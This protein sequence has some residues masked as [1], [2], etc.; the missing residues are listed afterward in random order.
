LLFSYPAKKKERKRFA[1]DRIT[2]SK[3][4]L[5]ALNE[6]EDVGWRTIARL[7]ASVDRVTDIPQMSVDDVMRFGITARRAEAIV[8]LLKPEALEARLRV[9]ERAGIRWITVW[10][11]VY[12][13]L[14]RHTAEP[15]WVLYAIGDI[16]LLNRHCLAIVGTRTPTAYGRKV[17]ENLA[18][19]LVRA[20]FCIVS[21]MA[22]GIDSAAH[23]GALRGGGDTIAVLA[24]GVE[25]V[26]PPE[27]RPLYRELADRGLIVS[28]SPLGTPMHPG[29]F[30]VRN[31]IIAG[32][33]LGTIVVEAADRSG[34][35]ITA[36]LAL[37]ASRDVFAVPGPITSPKSRGTLKL[38]KQGA[39][40]VTSPDDIAEEYMHMINTSESSYTRPAANVETLTEEEQKIYDML[41]GEPLTI[42]QLLERS[43]INFGHL[44]SV[45]L[46]LLLKKRIQQLSGP[47]YIALGNDGIMETIKR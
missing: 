38:I 35:L 43:Q 19:A 30:P 29:L 1:M 37:D 13:E 46:S 31:R 3:L 11:D 39:K 24:G 26:Y 21:G 27:N 36:D 10:D 7:V 17:A 2:D 32:L 23:W 45:L 8:R 6:A 28:E 4:I 40:I 16:A 9:Y 18:A 34:S 25:Q 42:D 41:L 33:S 5:F 44:H 20:G 12:P 22:R 15:P 47:S 14:L